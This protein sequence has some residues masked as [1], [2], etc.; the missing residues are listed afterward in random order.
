[1]V[2]FTKG[3]NV[4]NRHSLLEVMSFTFFGSSSSFPFPDFSKLKVT[5]LDPAKG[6]VREFTID[7]PAALAKDGC[8]ADQWLEWGDLIDIPEGEHR[9]NERWVGLRPEDRQSFANCLSRKVSISVKAK[10]NSV[11]L[12]APSNW[13]MPVG[14]SLPSRYQAAETFWLNQTVKRSGLLLTSS[15]LSR[16]AVRRLDIETGSSQE[17]T[18]DLTKEPSVGN[19]LWLRDGDVIEVPEKQ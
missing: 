8:S 6:S 17:W 1:M 14:E 13:V 15:D 4:W 19:D 7:L 5:R 9:L 10:T 18:F 11:D 12:L 3:T 16:V 2:V